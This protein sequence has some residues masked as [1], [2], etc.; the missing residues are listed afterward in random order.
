M[1]EDIRNAR[2]SE[3]FLGIE[4]HGMFMLAMTLDYGGTGQGYQVTFGNSS[5][6]QDAIKAV[7]KV[8]GVKSWE[9]LIGRYVRVRIEGGLVQNLM[10]LLGD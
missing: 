9:E 10:P 6:L 1:S 7:L 8:A 5:E 4:D 3:T 2:I